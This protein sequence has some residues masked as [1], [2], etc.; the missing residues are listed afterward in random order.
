MIRRRKYSKILIMNKTTL[1]TGVLLRS[2]RG[3]VM[4]TIIRFYEEVFHG[5]QKRYMI[6]VF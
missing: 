1:S 6:H 4:A 5:E 2:G 3:G